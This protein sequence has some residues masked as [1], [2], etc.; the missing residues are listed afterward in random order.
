MESSKPLKHATSNVNT[1]IKI[2]QTE[3][4][5]KQN[6]KIPTQ[7]T[8]LNIF[9]TRKS[10]KNSLPRSNS[11]IVDGKI[12]SECMLMF[13]FKFTKEKPFLLDE[14]NNALEQFR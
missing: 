1:L 12:W 13:T 3:F 6:V 9:L 7:K 5:S 4:S 2:F 8:L 10:N 11:M 14:A